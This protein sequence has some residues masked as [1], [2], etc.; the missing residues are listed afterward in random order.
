MRLEALCDK[1]RSPIVLPLLADENAVWRTDWAPLLALLAD[2]RLSRK[3]RAEK[4]HSSVA[5]ALLAQAMLA[6]D[7]CGAIRVGLTGGVFQNKVLAE[8]AVEL[9]TAAGFEVHLPRALPCN[10]AALCFGQI[11]EFAADNQGA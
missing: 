6:R 4:F 11:V 3:H 7:A 2:Q 5:H 1:H 8:E 9:L 10:D